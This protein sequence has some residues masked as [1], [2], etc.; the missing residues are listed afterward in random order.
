[1]SKEKKIILI[2][3]SAIIVAFIVAFILPIIYMGIAITSSEKNTK[4]NV[5]ASNGVEFKEV[6]T[7]H[8]FP[9]ESYEIRLY[10]KNKEFRRDIYDRN[11]ER[12]SGYE[13]PPDPGGCPAD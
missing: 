13:G 7:L 6:Y 12:D 9:D 5:I 1:M 4:L 8:S 10:G 11:Q 3:I 2:L